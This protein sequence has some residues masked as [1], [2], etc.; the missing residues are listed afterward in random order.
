MR[1]Y[2]FRRKEDWYPIQCFD[3]KD[4]LVHVGLNPGTLSVE[5]IE[6]RIVWPETKS[7]QK[8]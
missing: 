2:I 1:T 3:D 4:V 8:H 7:E 5:D 6:G